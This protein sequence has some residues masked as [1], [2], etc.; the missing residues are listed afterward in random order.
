MNYSPAT[1]KNELDLNRSIW[2]DLRKHV[3]LIRHMT[4]ENYTEMPIF[5]PISSAE[6]QK[7]DAIPC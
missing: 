2:K 6:K 5:P 4:N 7:F 3:L 1:K